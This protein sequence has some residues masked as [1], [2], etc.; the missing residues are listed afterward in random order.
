MRSESVDRLVAWVW[1]GKD[2]HRHETIRSRTRI[3]GRIVVIFPP[4]GAWKQIRSLASQSIGVGLS[5]CGI[6][7]VSVA[8]RLFHPHG[9]V[10][11]WTQWPGPGL[12]WTHCEAW[13]EIKRIAAVNMKIKS[14]R[15]RKAKA[16]RSG[17][18]H[19]A[20]DAEPFH[21]YCTAAQIGDFRCVQIQSITRTQ[22]QSFFSPR[23]AHVWSRC[24]LISSG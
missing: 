18:S 14:H 20:A 22:R 4:R 6:A 23:C 3:Q 2:Q 16:E 17:Q 8:A 11:F 19:D 9:L 21:E 24:P 1:V 7:E 5:P 13:P 15:H 10:R 12:G